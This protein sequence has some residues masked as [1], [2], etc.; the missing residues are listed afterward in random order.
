MAPH[1]VQ[2][3]SRKCEST[4][5]MGNQLAQ[6]QRLHREQLAELPNVVYK[7]LLGKPHSPA[8]LLPSF[9]SK[10]ASLC[11]AARTTNRLYDSCFGGC[12]ALKTVFC[13]NWATGG[14]RLLKTV[15][16]VHD[17][18]ALVVKVYHSRGEPVDLK[19]YERQLTEIR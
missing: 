15:L 17:I 19:P 11:A 1:I 2:L 6:P 13:A 10:W 7:E 16:C 18:G 3:Q 14:G 4:V 9:A 8:A 12:P 5:P